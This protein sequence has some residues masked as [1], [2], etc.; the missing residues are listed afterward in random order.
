MYNMYPSSDL[1]YH[2]YRL[3]FAVMM[4]IMA[5]LFYSSSARLLRFPLDRLLLDRITVLCLLG[6]QH[7]PFTRHSIDVSARVWR[8][9]L[10]TRQI[11]IVWMK[12]VP[13]PTPPLLLWRG[14]DMFDSFIELSVSAAANRRVCLAN[15]WAGNPKPYWHLDRKM[16]YLTTDFVPCVH[17]ITANI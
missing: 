8:G 17:M 14:A 3:A 4:M 1:L 16:M 10:D 11:H 13:P 15:I 6:A 7:S 9:R 5:T 2:L 12:G